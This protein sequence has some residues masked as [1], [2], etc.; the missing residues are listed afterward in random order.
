M[1]LK[2][3]GPLSVGK[4][5]AILQGVAGLIGGIFFAIIGLLGLA[6]G[7]GDGPNGIM[8][9]LFGG[10]A[11][12]ILPVLDALIGFIAGVIGALIYNVLAGLV[13][14]IEMVLE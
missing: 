2:S 8:A 6:A 3:V 13:G 12:I 5:F 9:L 4:I 7:T 14:G 1:V 11:I 10:A